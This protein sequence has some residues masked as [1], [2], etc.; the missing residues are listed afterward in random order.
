M[1]ISNTLSG[2]KEEFTPEGDPVKMYVCGITPQSAAHIGHAMSYI[3]FDVIR[4]YL[5]YSGR[6]VKYVQNFTDVDD[7]IIAKAVPLGLTPLALADRNIAEFQADMA[8]LNIMPADA[9]PRVTGE[10]PSIIELV[11]GLVDKGFA[12]E[13][14]GSVYFRV[15]K[16][17][18][19]GKLS[20]RTLDQMRAGARI[21]IGEDKEDPMDFVLWK[22]TKPGEPSWDSPWGKGRP[23]WHIECSAMSRKYLGETIDIHGGGADLIFPHHEN[24]IAQS[25]SFTGKKPFVRYWLHNG[26]L[27]LGGEKMSKS[28]GNLIT[29][30]DFLAKNSAD[31]LRIFVL[32]SHYRSPLTFSTEVIDGAEKGAQRLIQAI[33]AGVSGREKVDFDAAAYRKRFVEAMDDDFNTPRALAALFDLAREINR[34]EADGGDASAAKTLL[35]DLSSVLGLKLTAAK[36]A[37]DGGIIITTVTEVYRELGRKAPNWEGDTTRAMADVLALRAELRKNKDFISADLLRKKLEMIGVSLKDGG[38]SAWV[39]GIFI[40]PVFSDKPSLPSFSWDAI[41]GAT[42]YELMVS[43]SPSLETIVGHITT[44]VPVYEWSNPPLAANTTYYY[45]TRAI[46]GTTWEYKPR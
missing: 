25:E 20:H 17:D 33:K 10:I 40:T 9:Y 29:I 2:H 44:P 13:V 46:I 14:K 38:T 39:S 6:G 19:Y 41:P 27:Q 32:G 21:E 26:L 30:K 16:L 36:P 24:E 7:K 3:N 8:S 23:G 37:D 28:V 11:T 5:I 15:R 12:Y 18:D 31:A 1:K 42:S 22:A 45:Q 43:T 35:R 34:V 4:R